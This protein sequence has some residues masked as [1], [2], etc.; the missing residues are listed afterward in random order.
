MY[1]IFV[2]WA[3]VT[4]GPT[5]VPEPIRTLG[6]TTDSEWTIAPTSTKAVESMEAESWKVPPPL[7]HL[8]KLSSSDLETQDNRKGN[9]LIKLKERKG[10]K[11]LHRVRK[12]CG[13]V[14]H[15]TGR[16]RRRSGKWGDMTRRSEDI[17]KVCVLIGMEKRGWGGTS[18][19]KYPPS[20]HS[21]RH[22]S[23][24]AEDEK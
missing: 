3:I 11:K 21:H 4:E 13:M 20:S 5:T 17:E 12:M 18:K 15:F 19:S 1:P 22:Q 8:W 9:Q 2:E 10:K 7:C 6:P 24:W 16:R 14:I 23:L